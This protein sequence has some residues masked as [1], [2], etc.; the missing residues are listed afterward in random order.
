MK[1][2][3]LLLF[4]ASITTCLGQVDVAVMYLKTVERWESIDNFRDFDRAIRT[5]TQIDPIFLPH[6]ERIRSAMEKNSELGKIGFTEKD[7]EKVPKD[8]SESY[9]YIIQFRK[10]HLHGLRETYKEIKKQHK[11]EQDVSAKSLHATRSVLG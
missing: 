5:T 4:L 10:I 8:L 3:V 1:T 7:L 9:G 6:F 11:S 2:L